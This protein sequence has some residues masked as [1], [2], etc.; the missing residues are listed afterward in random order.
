MT[1]QL[2]INY[3][4]EKIAFESSSKLI[5][6]EN[7][8]V[9]KLFYLGMYNSDLKFYLYNIS[10]FN[11]FGYGAPVTL[12]G[13]TEIF[14]NSKVPY[15]GCHGLEFRDDT[16][17]YTICQGNDNNIYAVDIVINNLCK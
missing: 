13:Q 11:Q 10:D 12:V 9:Q 1:T 17:F 3:G 5:F 2:N 16:T 7:V 4:P 14:R 8:K 6:F 15:T